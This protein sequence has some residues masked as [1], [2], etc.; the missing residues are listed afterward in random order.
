MG[1]AQ[2]I[3]PKDFDKIENINRIIKFFPAYT[4]AGNTNERNAVNMPDFIIEGIKGTETEKN[5]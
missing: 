2:Y 4:K 3:K 1:K 5:L